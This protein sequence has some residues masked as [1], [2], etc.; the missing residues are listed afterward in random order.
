[1]S[2]RMLTLGK[3]NY[4]KKSVL[5]LSYS[6]EPQAIPWGSCMLR[7]ILVSPMLLQPFTLNAHV[8]EVPLSLL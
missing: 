1:M 8:S 2:L 5:R 4:D 7:E 6:K 3:G